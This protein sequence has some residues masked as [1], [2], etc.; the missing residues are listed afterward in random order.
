[1]SPGE[2]EEDESGGADA[3]SGAAKAVDADE[4]A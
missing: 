1:L 3:G 4:G 2:D